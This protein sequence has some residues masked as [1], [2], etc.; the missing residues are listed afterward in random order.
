M[1]IGIGIDI[2]ELNR[3]EDVLNRQPK[4]VDR[5]LT[6]SEKN[7]YLTLSNRRKIEF[8]AGRFAAKEAFVK[9]VGTGISASY[10]WRDIEVKKEAN[11]KPYVIASGLTDQVHLSISHSKM[12]AVAQVLI[13]SLSS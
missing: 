9:A 4:F 7:T 3:I 13:E 2:V 6:D 1:I 10:S 8:L 5:I 11:G 12:Y